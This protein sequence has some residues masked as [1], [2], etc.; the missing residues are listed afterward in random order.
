MPISAIS[1]SDQKDKIIWKWTLNG[2]YTVASA[3]NCQFLGAMSNFHALVIWTATFDANSKFF[4]WLVLHKGVLTAENMAKR[5]WPCDPKC[6]FC[7]CLDE[8]T[9]HILILSECNYTEAA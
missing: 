2:K 7:L 3:Y 4:V 1:L 6:S 5:N 8:T 9:E